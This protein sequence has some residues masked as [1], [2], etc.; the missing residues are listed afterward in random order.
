MDLSSKGTRDELVLERENRF[1]RQRLE[2]ACDMGET[3][4]GAAGVMGR[5]CCICLRRH[6]SRSGVCRQGGEMV[7][8]CAD[9]GS[10]RIKMKKTKKFEKGE[11]QFWKQEE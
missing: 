8:A 7:H 4:K 5:T 11:K 6:C 10:C 3:E 2:T 1:Y 9:S